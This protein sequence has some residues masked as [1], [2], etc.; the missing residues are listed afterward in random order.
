M[1]LKTK[2]T[3][4]VLTA[5]M[6]TLTACS[7]STPTNVSSKT[8][9]VAYVKVPDV[10]G[11]SGDLA[12]KTLQ[13]SQLLYSWS[14]DV[15]AASN[16]TVNSTVPKAGEKV[17]VN[18]K[19]LLN[20]TKKQDESATS[21]SPVPAAPSSNNLA[22]T[23]N[24]TLLQ[25]LNVTT[26]AECLQTDPSNPIGYISSVEDGTGYVRVKVQTTISKDEAKL[27][28]IRIFNLVG[29][30]IPQ[31]DTLVITDASGIDVNVFRS[32]SPLLNR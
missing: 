28:G 16:W 23:V 22:A 14:D 8:P 2:I 25:A 6:L 24:S 11:M 29:E 19:V 20:V 21:P 7:S 27:L 18:T 9:D 30:Q 17:P 13:A 15:W 5:V 31:L 4:L 32:E 12:K 1:S 3:A 26:Y 10:V